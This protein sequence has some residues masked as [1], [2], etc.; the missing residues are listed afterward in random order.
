M[1]F[2]GAGTPDKF[3]R[4]IRPRL[5]D[6]SKVTPGNQNRHQGQVTGN[7]LH[8]RSYRRCCAL[9]GE[10][11]RERAGI[12]GQDGQGLVPH[13]LQQIRKQLDMAVSPT[14]KLAKQVKKPRAWVDPVFLADIECRDNTS[15]GLLR[16]SSF[17][18]LTRKER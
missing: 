15:K 10:A 14:S 9:P 8:Q 18:G 17:K 5:T 12:F 6:R 11:R 1:G 4:S 13:S 7:R 16:Q 2:S 3:R